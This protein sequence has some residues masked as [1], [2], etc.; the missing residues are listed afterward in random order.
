MDA[1][2]DQR[3]GAARTTALGRRAG[4]GGHCVE[5]THP[6]VQGPPAVVPHATPD[7]PQRP[8]DNYPVRPISGRRGTSSHTTTPPYFHCSSEQCQCNALGPKPP[9]DAG[10]ET[11]G[12]A[13]PASIGETASEQVLR[14]STSTLRLS[15]EVPPDQSRNFSPRFG[16]STVLDLW[17]RKIL[18]YQAKWLTAPS[19]TPESGFQRCLKSMRFLW[20]TWTLTSCCTP[21]LIGQ[22]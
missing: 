10:T 6:R 19:L 8:T 21:L 16:P 11:H 12:E 18:W 7:T 1:L 14:A 22:R 2:G 5:S 17:I 13:S 4:H 3:P 20:E 9:Q 15:R